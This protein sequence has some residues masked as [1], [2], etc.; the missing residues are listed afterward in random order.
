LKPAENKRTV[1]TAAKVEADAQ[2]MKK[3]AEMAQVIEALEGSVVELEKERDF[4]FGKLRNVELMLQVQ[5]DNNFD[6]CYTQPQKRMS[7]LVQMER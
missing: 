5:Q 3:N 2:M 4:Y 7:K 1:N 6:G